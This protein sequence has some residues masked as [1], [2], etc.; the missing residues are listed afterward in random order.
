MKEESSANPETDPYLTVLAIFSSYGENPPNQE[1]FI[2]NFNNS[3]FTHIMPRIC[4]RANESCYQHQINSTLDIQ[5]KGRRKINQKSKPVTFEYL[6][7]LKPQD[8][9]KLIASGFGQSE[10]GTYGGISPHEG[11]KYAL[12]C[13][14]QS[15]RF[16]QIWSYQYSKRV[17]YIYY[18][19]YPTLFS[20]PNPA[21]NSPVFK[22]PS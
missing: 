3:N 20:H 18:R 1:N 5:H 4:K 10:L 2:T 13:L 12:S 11:Y 16:M 9:A 21:L 19:A 15:Q 6:L 14:D 22:T 7:R 17:L 8:E